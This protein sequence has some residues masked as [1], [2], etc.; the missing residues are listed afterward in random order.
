MT[1]ENIQTF[2][3][4]TDK[5]SQLYDLFLKLSDLDNQ[6][7]TSYYLDA[8]DAIHVKQDEYDDLLGQIM[9][10]KDF[11]DSAIAFIKQLNQSVV[12]NDVFQLMQDKRALVLRRVYNDL[13]N[14]RKTDSKAFTNLLTGYFKQESDINMNNN[15]YLLLALFYYNLEMDYRV[16]ELIKL[17]PDFGD[18]K[19]L[20]GFLN[21]T[22][23]NIL[24]ETHYAEVPHSFYGN[25]MIE[26]ELSIPDKKKIEYRNAYGCLM[27]SK[28]LTLLKKN[29]INFDKTLLNAIIRSSNLFMDEDTLKEVL[30][31]LKNDPL[32]TKLEYLLKYRDKD[33]KQ[34]NQFATKLDKNVMKI[35]NS[36]FEVTKTI[37]DIYS[38]LRTLE[39][40]GKRN[41]PQYQSM[42]NY[43]DLTLKEEQEYYD[44]FKVCEE[45]LPSATEY[46]FEI[47]DKKNY[48]DFAT[49]IS[50]DEIEDELICVRIAKKFHRMA[51]SVEEYF[52]DYAED[53]DVMLCTT[54]EDFNYI[55]WAMKDYDLL[56][57]YNVQRSLSTMKDN[58]EALKFKYNM[59][60]VIPSI[61]RAM[62]EGNLDN[63]P[64]IFVPSIY[65]NTT[66]VSKEVIT[67]KKNK[68]ALHR[69]TLIIDDI[70]EYSD[71]DVTGEMTEEVDHNYYNGNE[72]EETNEELVNEVLGQRTPQYDEEYVEMTE[73][74]Y[75]KQQKEDEDYYDLVFNLFLAEFKSSL[76]FADANTLEEIKKKIDQKY[77][78]LNKG[79]KQVFNIIYSLIEEARISLKTPQIDQGTSYTL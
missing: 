39:K 71:Y 37:R 76:R 51:L 69:I 54:D 43:L 24:K 78:Y 52:R 21:P 25:T 20:L 53:D 48:R 32:Y 55:R 46:V 14:L 31:A 63:L 16:I 58:N 26:T 36:I 79:R 17:N 3:N 1:E 27:F 42:I 72:D 33:M 38:S 30:G 47:L 11:L 2:S 19:Y 10:D 56:Y 49:E 5:A 9:E 34:A 41:T 61:E 73:E 23:H 75:E 35:I 4:I 15:A 45:D 74:E 40:A 66:G 65:L 77:K 62:L 22:V 60:F 59:A 8:L 64:D 68:Y 50:L 44:Y 13:T 12:H 6:K 29:N 7:N 67:H 18:I 57:N 70:I 28:A